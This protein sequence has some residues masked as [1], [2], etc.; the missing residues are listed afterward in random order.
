MQLLVQKFGGTSLQ[1][2][3]S[4][5]HVLY[6][7][8]EAIEENYKVVVVVSALGKVPA[9]YATDSLLQLVN[10]PET[11]AADRELDL[12]LS[13]GEII[14]AVVVANELKRAGVRATAFTGAQAGI[15]TTE[16]HMN[17]RIQHVNPKRLLHA[18][19]TYDCVVVAGF[20][21]ETKNG[22]ITTIGRGGSDTTA[23]ALA[24]ATEA[25]R[26]EIFTDVDGVMTADPKLVT[27]AQVLTNCTYSE[28]CNLA[29]QGAKVIHPQAVEIAMQAKLP[30]HVRSTYKRNHGTIISNMQEDG[31]QPRNKKKLITGIAHQAGIA[32]VKI[33]RKENPDYSMTA[34]FKALAAAGISIDFINI[35][36]N[37]LA[38]TL[39]NVTLPYAKQIF[40]QL[41]LHVT[42]AEHCAKIAAVGAGMTGIPGVASKI[43]SA[44]VEQ[45]IQILQAADSHTTIWVLVPEE[46]LKQAVNAL[47][48]T[49]RLSEKVSSLL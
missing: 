38:F 44:L 21:G 27:S 48:E 42:M 43:V 47:H 24:V 11:N 19:D 13:C 18:F 12:L 8:K 17:A 9:P 35:S 10:Y 6:H 5:K 45:D 16:N 34:I 49:F 37:Q 22:D 29:Y 28:T 26:A 2:P 4:R 15:M 30:L 7:V 3:S 32:Q 25:V 14:S 20:Q 31:K 39:P 36:P 1:T 40:K 23:A 46:K 33:K 41:D